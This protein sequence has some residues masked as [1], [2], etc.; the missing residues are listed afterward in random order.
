[1][2]LRLTDTPIRVLIGGSR[3]IGELVG[4]TRR[5]GER[6]SLLKEA[7]ESVEGW[8]QPVQGFC[9][10]GNHATVFFVEECQE[11]VEADSAV[12]C[13]LADVVEESREGGGA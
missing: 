10:L 13:N 3:S 9:H 12:T 11:V 8:S 1:M 5:R 4:F 6:S 2:K 7:P